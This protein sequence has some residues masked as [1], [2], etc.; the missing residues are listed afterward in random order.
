[1]YRYAA[2][3]PAIALALA[4]APTA[5]AAEAKKPAKEASAKPVDA[6]ASAPPAVP[7]N[8]AKPAPAN[9]SIAGQ[10]RDAAM[11]MGK[12]FTVVVEGQGPDVILIPGLSTP[13]AVWDE[14]VDALAGCYT[15]HSV[16]LRGFGDDAGVNAEGPVLEPFVTELADYI[17]D[18]IINKGRPAPAII[19]HS[20]GGLSALMI[21]ARQPQLAGKIMVVDALP[22]IGTIFG[23]PDVATLRP[24]AEAMA[25]SLRARYKP[26]VPQKLTDCAGEAASVEVHSI[27]SNTPEGGCKV[28]HWSNRSDPRVTAQAL[29]DDALVD[30]RPELPKITSPVTLLYPQ[31]DRALPEAAVRALYEGQYSGTPKF[32]PVM[33]KG[34]YHFIMLDQ[35]KMYLEKVSDFLKN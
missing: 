23:A 34:S 32:T 22:F 2:C 11:A 4:M 17:D 9:C 19:G 27:W 10:S 35:P 30:M 3:L 21:G 25:A 8:A 18:E 1:M 33:V 14:T 20:M 31:D 6:P 13:R 28:E 16:Q 7:A 12:R 29:L 15:L 5:Q 26:G 24:R